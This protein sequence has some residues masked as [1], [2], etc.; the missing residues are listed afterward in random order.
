MGVGILLFWGRIPAIES[1]NNPKK[2]QLSDFHSHD[3]RGINGFENN[4]EQ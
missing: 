4:R 2:M 3:L 1:G